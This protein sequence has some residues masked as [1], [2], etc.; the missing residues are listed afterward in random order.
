MPETSEQKNASKT[1]PRLLMLLTIGLA[2]LVL[3]VM[4]L[5]GVV[6]R[7]GRLASVTMQGRTENPSVR[8]LLN[9]SSEAP[10]KPKPEASPSTSTTLQHTQA[11]PLRFE[12]LIPDAPDI[13]ERLRKGRESIN[14]QFDSLLR[15]IE[16]YEQNKERL[17]PEQAKAEIDQAS[18]T[19]LKIY[20]AVMEKIS[21]DVLPVFTPFPNDPALA[22]IY[23]RLKDVNWWYEAARIDIYERKGEWGVAGNFSEWRLSKRRNDWEYSKGNRPV[24][25]SDYFHEQ[26]E[27]DEEYKQIIFC[28]WKQGGVNGYSK[29]LD[30][31]LPHY[32]EKFVDAWKRSSAEPKK[33]ERIR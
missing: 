20:E 1:R 12:Q 13:P 30:V 2:L 8:H 15:R 31:A 18:Q 19:Y 16:Q 27:A 32:Y 28:Y 6:V 7:E 23:T 25:R 22:P 10:S 9:P 17:T 11:P 14:A 21:D 29:I 5:T 4:L 24:L 3:F 26:P 33:T